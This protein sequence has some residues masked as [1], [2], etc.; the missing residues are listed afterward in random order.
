[1]GISVPYEGFQLNT[2][3]KDEN[4]SIY[5]WLIGSNVEFLGFILVNPLLTCLFVTVEVVIEADIVI[6]N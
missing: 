4:S 3:M 1:M 5:E 2:K 6:Y